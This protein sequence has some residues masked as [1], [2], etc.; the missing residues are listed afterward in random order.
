MDIKIT[1]ILINSQA[2]IHPFSLNLDLGW[3]QNIY[4]FKKILHMILIHGCYIYCWIIIEE[5]V[6]YIT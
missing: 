5:V 1:K 3:D 2:L 6:C 4:I